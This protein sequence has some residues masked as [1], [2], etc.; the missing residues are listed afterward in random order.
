V[1]RAPE[2]LP[3]DIEERRT[4]TMQTPESPSLEAM[5][6][7][8][9]REE[10]FAR[11]RTLPTNQTVQLPLQ[12]GE[13]VTFV[14][15]PKALAE[16]AATAANPAAPSTEAASAPAVNVSNPAAPTAATATAQ[17]AAAE[18]RP[19]ASPA[20]AAEGQTKLAATPVSEKSAAPAPTEAV[21][22]VGEVG[23]AVQPSA[24]TN[25]KPAAAANAVNATNAAAAAESTAELLLL[26]EQQELKVGERRRV[27]VFMKTDAPVGLATA[28]LRFDPRT[29]AVRSVSQGVLS[30]DKSAAP[31]LTQTVDASKGVLLVS[32]TPASGAPPL[33]GE[34][35]LLVVEV[36]G[37]AE[38]E[39]VLQFD[40]DKVHLIATDG[41]TVR[42]RVSAGKLKVTR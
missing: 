33:T 41:R 12:P 3:A 30:A 4:G 9:E 38:G 35:L 6:R 8:A 28:T 39:A 36:E 22:P 11:Q 2:I 25:S 5:V 17:P 26:P 19:A 23:A 18:A 27:M 13:D 20:V 1:L 24:A 15:A 29:L 10:Y 34:G 31:V 42:P 7:D 40:A 37:L 14:P 32:V 16:S 21:K